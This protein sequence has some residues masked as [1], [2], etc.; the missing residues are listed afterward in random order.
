MFFQMQKFTFNL[1]EIRF[2]GPLSIWKNEMTDPRV[3]VYFDSQFQ[4]TLKTTFYFLPGKTVF[5]IGTG[6]KSE[7]GLTILVHL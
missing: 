5:S 2:P 1:S 3:L 4:E 6:G 7:L